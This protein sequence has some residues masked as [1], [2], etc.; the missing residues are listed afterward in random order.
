MSEYEGFAY[1]VD[2]SANGKLMTA[3]RAALAP[4]WK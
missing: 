3:I 2:P 4:V 1:D